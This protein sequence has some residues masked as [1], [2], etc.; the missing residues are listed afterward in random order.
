MP[1]CYVHV[2]CLNEETIPGKVGAQ[3]FEN[4]SGYEP[5][6]GCLFVWLYYLLFDVSD[7][8]VGKNALRSYVNVI[9]YLKR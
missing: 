2:M 1:S 3:E 9:F 4:D 7:L 8:M 6:F 5:S